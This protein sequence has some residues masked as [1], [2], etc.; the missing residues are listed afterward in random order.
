MFCNRPHRP[1]KSRAARRWSWLAPAL[2]VLGMLLPV[3]GWPACTQLQSLC[4]AGNSS[5]DGEREFPA[6]DEGQDSDDGDLEAHLFL[7]RSPRE[8]L[9][10]IV[11]AESIETLVKNRDARAFPCAARIERHAAACSAAPLVLRC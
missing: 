7:R 3:T 4:L 1:G 5:D 11:V 2:A 6:D 10:P 9:P 8:S